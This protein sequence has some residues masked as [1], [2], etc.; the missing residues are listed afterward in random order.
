[1]QLNPPGVGA[2]ARPLDLKFK[3]YIICRSIKYKWSV[4]ELNEGRGQ[5]GIAPVAN[6]AE[7]K[8]RL[9]GP[10]GSNE[11]AVD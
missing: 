5:P 6:V 7:R 2:S 9:R 3:Y 1:M 8:P 4:I 10:I 11:M